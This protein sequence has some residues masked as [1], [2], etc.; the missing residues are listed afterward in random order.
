MANALQIIQQ[1]LKAPKSCF[2]SFGKYHYRN[3]EDILEAVKPLLAET[4][5][6]LTLSDD[7]VDL[8]GFVFVKV[9]ATLI[10]FFESTANTSISCR[11]WKA[12]AFARH[13]AQQ[14]GMNDAQITG[15]ASSYARKYALNGLFLIDD[16]KD[17][18]ATNTH[19]KEEEKAKKPAKAPA[20]NSAKEKAPTPST[21]TIEKKPLTLESKS[22]GSVVAKIKSGVT[23]ETIKGFFTL[24]PEVEQKLIEDSK[25]TT[26]EKK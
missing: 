19:G 20:K 24:T 17:A 23:L 11:E 13:A 22:Y 2:N 5:S 3:Q 16:T 7:I 21:A 10:E 6:I 15:S 18:D 25:A 26:D 8:G 9:T 12:T 14:S 4:N 1:K